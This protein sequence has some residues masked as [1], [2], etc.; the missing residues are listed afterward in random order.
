VN[1]R[2]VHYFINGGRKP[3]DG[4]GMLLA[5]IRVSLPRTKSTNQ[6]L[7]EF[8]II[9]LPKKDIPCIKCLPNLEIYAISV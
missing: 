6:F 9:V 5:P 3:T 7:A 8:I 1:N 2:Y 4:A